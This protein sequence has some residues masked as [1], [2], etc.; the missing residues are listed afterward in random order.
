MGAFHVHIAH[1]DVVLSS[2]SRI[3][4]PALKGDWRG[5]TSQIPRARMTRVRFPTSATCYHWC[6]RYAKLVGHSDSQLE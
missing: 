1:L 4:S 2:S 5:L 3:V 6:M